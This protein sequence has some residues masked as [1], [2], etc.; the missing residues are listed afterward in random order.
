LPKYKREA[1]NNLKPLN[2]KR[3]EVTESEPEHD[4]PLAKKK[5]LFWPTIEVI[6]CP[7]RAFL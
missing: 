4:K 7:E 5:H 3:Q 2:N 1:K 6:H